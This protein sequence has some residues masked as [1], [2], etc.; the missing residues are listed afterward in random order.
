MRSRTAPC[1]D[2]AELLQRHSGA[3]QI[4]VQDRLDGRLRG[5]NPRRLNQRLD[6]AERLGLGS[7]GLN[8]RALR[9]V[10]LH[11]RDLKS[12]AFQN[13]G[14]VISRV[15]RVIGHQN[16]VSAADAAGDGLANAAGTDDNCYV[17]HIS[18]PKS[19]WF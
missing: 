3:V 18:S 10:G 13:L 11:R 16:M 14:G 15:L 12:R 17:G 8:V 4:Y 7:H 2:L 19:A 5:R 9:V 1:H 6:R